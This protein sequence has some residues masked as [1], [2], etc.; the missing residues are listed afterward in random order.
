MTPAPTPAPLSARSVADVPQP[1]SDTAATTSKRATRGSVV[2]SACRLSFGTVERSANIER[3]SHTRIALR[4]RQ[5]A[6]MSHYIRATRA[7][8]DKV[9][10]RFFSEQATSTWAGSFRCSSTRASRGSIGAASI[11]DN[12]I[13]R[14]D[15]MLCARSHSPSP[16]GAVCQSHSM[17]PL[18]NVP[19]G[20]K[21]TTTMPIA[22]SPLMMRMLETLFG[23]RLPAALIEDKRPKDSRSS[24]KPIMRITPGTGSAPMASGLPAVGARAQPGRRRHQVVTRHA[25]STSW[26]AVG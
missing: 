16:E 2:K 17:E 9:D 3:H 13:A 22:M 10:L 25:S 14:P 4:R 1:A 18:T 7:I 5:T 21:R 15:D 8:G 6:E 12:A 26:R 24:T 11:A 19:K 23:Y 20:R